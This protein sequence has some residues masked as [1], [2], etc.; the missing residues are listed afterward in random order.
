MKITRRN[1]LKHE[2]IG[3]HVKVVNSPDPS[4]TGIKGAVIDETKNLLVIRTE[5][6]LKKI[7]K[8]YRT[9]EFKLPSGE[10]VQVDGNKIVLR[11]EDRVKTWP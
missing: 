2:L 4:Q 3:L 5:K 8:K 9:F 1:I 6:G 10:R 7:E 11:P